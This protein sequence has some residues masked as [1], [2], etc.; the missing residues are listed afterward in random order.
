MKE[1]VDELVFPFHLT[2]SF[3]PSPND[4]LEWTTLL[5]SKNDVMILAHSAATLLCAQLGAQIHTCR[6]FPPPTHH[7]TTN[8]EELL[9]S[10]K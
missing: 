3:I 4:F 6:Y 2:S 10:E 5:K 1:I 8:F 7:Y 9:I